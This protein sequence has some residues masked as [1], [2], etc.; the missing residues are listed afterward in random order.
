MATI[1]SICPTDEIPGSELYG[2]E[3]RKY[4]ADGVIS[5]IRKNPGSKLPNSPTWYKV[6]DDGSLK[7][8]HVRI[9]ST[10]VRDEEVTRFWILKDSREFHEYLSPIASRGTTEIRKSQ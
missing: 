2:T 3:V 1:I 6:M 5:V 7:K 10:E 9:I 4:Y 8:T